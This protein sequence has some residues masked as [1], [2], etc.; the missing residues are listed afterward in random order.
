[1][2]ARTRLAS[3]YEEWRL[4]SESEGDAIRSAAWPRVEHCQ[5]VKTGLRQKILAAM[6][7]TD[8]GQSSPEDMRR[9]FRP[10]LEHLIGLEL[11]NSQLLESQHSRLEADRDQLGHHEHNLRRL[12]HAYGARAVS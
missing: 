11:R 9:H 3:L 6:E 8:S 7:A 12:H 4:M 10:I 5:N 2:N 1:M